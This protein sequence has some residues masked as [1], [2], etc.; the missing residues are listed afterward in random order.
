MTA[1]I[2]TLN[3]HEVDAFRELLSL[4]RDVF[5]EDEEDEAVLPVPEDDYL[6]TV[7]ADPDF[8]AVIARTESGMVMGGL[9]L[10][11][12]RSYSQQGDECYLY[13]LAV[14]GAHRRQGV[15]AR[16]VEHAIALA[17]A[18]NAVA[19]WVQAEAGDEDAVGFYR[20]LQHSE[21]DV[22]HFELL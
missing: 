8:V 11:F 5:A 14:H 2:T 10:R 3:N 15:A 19:M 6:A 20:S 7:L 18:R 1:T 17:K 13:D 16:L 22:S 4:F 21:L 9:T 12:W